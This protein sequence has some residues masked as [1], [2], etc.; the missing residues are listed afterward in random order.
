MKLIINVIIVHQIASFA[1]IKTLV[2]DVILQLIVYLL[3]SVYKIAPLLIFQL[4]LPL[5]QLVS[6]VK[7]TV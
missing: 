4:I 7:L 2:L 6:R 5:I 3:K 1:Q